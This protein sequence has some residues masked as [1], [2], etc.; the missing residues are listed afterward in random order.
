M[1]ARRIALAMGALTLLWATLAGAEPIMKPRK[2]HG[3]IPQ[4]MVW[5][6]AGMF[7]GASNEEMNTY[8]DGLVTSPFTA[9]SEDFGTSLA[10]EA[11]YAH[12]PH[13]QF[14]VRLNASVSFLSSPGSWNGVAEVPGIPDSI[15]VVNYTR[16]F[17]SKLIVLEASRIYFFSDAAVEEFQTYIGAGFSF[18]I[19]YEKF[20]ETQANAESGEVYSTDESSEWGFSPGVHAV[21]GALYY[22]DN[23]FAVTAEGRLQQMKGRYEQLQAL[24]ET[25]NLEDVNF[26]ID[27]AGFYLTVGMAWGF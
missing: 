18:G 17:D 22:I 19:P 11:G 10:V 2:Y 24:N 14:A 13:P 9:T 25:F 26:E 12:K 15:A 4:S 27:Y 16:D 23:R 5:L 8:L 7:G 21:I 3:P 1:S 6:R 20:T